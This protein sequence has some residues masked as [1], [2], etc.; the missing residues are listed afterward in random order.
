MGRFESDSFDAVV[1]SLVMCTVPVASVPEALKEIRRVLKPG[2]KFY[3]IE[4]VA[5]KPGTL[6][7]YANSTRVVADPLLNLIEFSG[8]FRSC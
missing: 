1:V 4:H 3:F 2:G 8:W 7:R 6:R 5:D